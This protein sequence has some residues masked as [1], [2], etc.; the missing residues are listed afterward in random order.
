MTE[1]QEK[2]RK[3]LT[4]RFNAILIKQGRINEKEELVWNFTNNRT[5]HSSECTIDE[6]SQMIAAISDSN[7]PTAQAPSK[8]ENQELRRAIIF[9]I[10]KL[11]KRFGW[12][13]AVGDKKKFSQKGFNDWLTGS[14]KSPFKKH[15]NALTT[16]ELG[17]LKGLLDKWI[18]YYN[19]KPEE[20][21][22]PTTT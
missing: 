1:K 21:E 6:L 2:Y 14:K 12:W 16:S 10:Y 22:Q 3:Q 13:I 8:D 9:R 7:A 5:S 17:K 15:F 4:Q 11:P 18:K 19:E 20:C